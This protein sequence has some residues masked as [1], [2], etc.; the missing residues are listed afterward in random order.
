MKKSL[1]FLC[2]AILF[3]GSAAA[4]I[5]NEKVVKIFKQSFPKAE[6]IKW[7]EYES[8]DEVCFEANDIRYRIDY[9][10][11]GKIVAGMRYYS[12][13]DLP[14]FIL[15]KVKEK[16]KDKSVFCVTEVGDEFG[17]KYTIVLQDEKNW[18]YVESDSHG[19]INLKDKFKKA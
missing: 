10:H 5:T 1:A 19:S 2:L 15:A 6:N 14:P 9:D 7:A 12:E 18:F 8:F 16:Y 13:K 3:A 4:G 17:L 11:D